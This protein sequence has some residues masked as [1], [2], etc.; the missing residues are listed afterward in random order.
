MSLLL[1]RPING[2]PSLG[3]LGRSLINNHSAR[4]ITATSYV[5]GEVQDITPLQEYDRQVKL[6][7]LRD[8]PFQRGILKSMEHMYK[9]L[10]A[11]QPPSTDSIKLPLPIQNLTWRSKLLAKFRRPTDITDSDVNTIGENLPKGIYLYGDVGCGKTML[12]DLFYTTIPKSLSK[13]RIHFHQFMQYVHKRSHEISQEQQEL[14]EDP[15]EEIDTIPFLAKEIAMT[16]RVLCFDEFQVTDVADA[17]ILRRLFS[18]ILGDKYGVIL[19]TTS[20]RE[21]N[22]LYINGIQRESF[23]PCIELIK[24]RTEVICLD[25]ETD[26]RKIP[27][28]VSSVYYYPKNE[29]KYSS[30]ECELFRKNHISKWY[31]YFAQVD[32]SDPVAAQKK[33]VYK[34]FNDYPLTIWGREFKVPK[35]T[36]PRVAQFTFKQLCGQPLAAGDYL[37]LAKNFDAFIVT[38]IPYLSIFV[39]DEIRRFITFLDAVYDNGGKL[40]TTGAANFTDL[41]VEPEDI[42]NDYEL[43]P[44]PQE[45]EEQAQ[46]EEQVVNS[47]AL[48]AKHGFSKEVAKKSH[49]F[50]LDEERFAF[51]RALS[52]LTQMSSTEW[53]TKKKIQ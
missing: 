33:S 30:R 36:P 38:D 25:S 47:D 34:E 46:Q 43:K 8:D 24:N 21:P 15:H 52:R 39:R 2:I 48:V 13:K 7:K 19:F 11:Y 23:I 28:P 45:T 31:E 26:Y 1:L 14:R 42:L 22:D 40:S 3:K 50:A 18:T 4:F 29:L 9:D 37:I 17:M 41:F 10:L 5:R 49:I 51:A 6:G 35:C 53:V 44:K 32:E 16:S 27:K 20:N 12:M